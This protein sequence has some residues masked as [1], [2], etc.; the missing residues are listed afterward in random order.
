MP[1][2]R[3]DSGG[4]LDGDLRAAAGGD[5]LDRPGMVPGARVVEVPCVAAGRL[6]RIR[7][8]HRPRPGAQRGLV[9]RLDL[10]QRVGVVDD[11]R[12]RGP[13]GATLDTLV[14]RAG[15]GLGRE[16]PKWTP[17]EDTDEPRKAGGQEDA[18]DDGSEDG[19]SSAAP[20]PP[21]A[22][23]HRR[24]HVALRRG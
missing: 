21:T 10:S 5:E 23:A 12:F 4:V 7:A 2:A 17:R 22:P 20:Q 11:H 18:N 14:D 3:R 24:L 13:A 16:L 8:V 15:T 9:V 19:A 6:T 1:V